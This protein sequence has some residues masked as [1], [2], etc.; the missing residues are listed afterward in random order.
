MH[1]AL[2][3]GMQGMAALDPAI[4]TIPSLHPSSSACLQCLMP[5]AGWRRAAEILAAMLPVCSTGWH[6]TAELLL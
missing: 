5:P 4:T 6:Y 2:R 1:G 3:P